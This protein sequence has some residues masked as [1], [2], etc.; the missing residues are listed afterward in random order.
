MQWFRSNLLLNRFFVYINS[1][2]TQCL[3]GNVKVVTFSVPFSHYCCCFAFQIVI[4][5]W[6]QQRNMNKTKNIK[7]WI[8]SVCFLFWIFKNDFVT[9][10]TSR[11][12]NRSNARKILI[13]HRS[14][15]FR[16]CINREI[17]FDFII[18][19]HCLR[20]NNVNVERWMLTSISFIW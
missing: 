18:F 3:I 17:E 8:C 6:L 15:S 13:I 10:L 5:F 9:R 7:N 11:K 12:K 1:R 14:L 4:W 19:C 20:M 2:Y 16:I